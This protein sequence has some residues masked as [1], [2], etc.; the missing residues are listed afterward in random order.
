M[1]K[2]DNVINLDSLGVQNKVFDSYETVDCEVL[3]S[4][5]ALELSQSPLSTKIKII[6]IDLCFGSDPTK[7]KFSIKIEGEV[8]KSDNDEII[9]LRRRFEE[10]AETQ[11]RHKIKS[12]ELIDFFWSVNEE[13]KFTAIS[14]S[15]NLYGNKEKIEHEEGRLMLIDIWGTWC[16]FCV[17]PMNKNV[18][19]YNE[20]KETYP[21]IDFIGIANDPDNTHRNWVDFVKSRKWNQIIQYRN[22]KII[23]NLGITSIPHL[24]LVDSKGSIVFS[25]NPSKISNLKSKLIEL[26]T[27][28]EKDSKNNEVVLENL[29]KRIDPNPQWLQN[30]KTE[31]NEIV[32]TINELIGSYNITSVK[33]LV[34]TKIL[35]LNKKT[36]I[37]SQ[38]ILSGYVSDLNFESLQQLGIM[39]SEDFGLKDLQYNVKLLTTMDDSTID[40]V[41]TMLQNK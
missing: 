5:L 25:D 14:D 22:N 15:F 27:S 26:M 16:K 8:S 36:Y 17:E 23:E 3:S 7:N 6:A 32:D 29:T 2:S 4:A 35:Y 28:S 10:I 31:R 40:Q 30:S 20:L 19:L 18:A 39:I 1:I 21:N 12:K 13:K 9:Y 37:Y 34:S 24:I 38:P 33:F 11:I 41:K